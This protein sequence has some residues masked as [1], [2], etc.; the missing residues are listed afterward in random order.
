[1]LDYDAFDM[2]GGM[3]DGEYR[4][5]SV[6]R[7]RGELFRW[8]SLQKQEGRAV[9]ELQD[10][11]LSWLGT[12]DRPALSV[13][14]AAASG[15]LMEFCAYVASRYQD[16]VPGGRA[17][18]GCGE[19]LVRY[20]SLTRASPLVL[21]R[22]TLQGIADSFARFLTLRQDAGIAWKPKSTSWCICR[23]TQPSSAI[24]I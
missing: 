12:A 7:L 8:Y 1:L 14:K 10:F 23:K 13:V 5:L 4:P 15:S 20:L 22:K 16:R 9:H 21:T 19:C 24:R 18:A 6:M 2:R 11:R 17:L 3:S